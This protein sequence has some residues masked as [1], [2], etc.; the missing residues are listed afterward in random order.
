MDFPVV[1]S[2]WSR[3]VPSNEIRPSNETYPCR[4]TGRDLGLELR[5]GELLRSVRGIQGEPSQPAPADVRIR[6]RSE[7]RAVSDEGG[8]RR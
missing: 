8:S 5:V 1:Q 3:A 4:S 2:V 7:S 6:L